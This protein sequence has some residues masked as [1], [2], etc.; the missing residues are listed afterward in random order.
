MA[1][2]RPARAFAVEGPPAPVSRP[3]P[4]AKACRDRC[5][6]PADSMR[7]RLVL[8]CCRGGPAPEDLE[9]LLGSGVGGRV[10]DDDQAAV[11]GRF[12]ALVVDGDVADD[13]VVEVLD[14]ADVE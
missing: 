11:G 4:C 3:W 9:R 14:A 5:R 8:D 1:K 10:R 13:A 7:R 2:A 6:A 12:E